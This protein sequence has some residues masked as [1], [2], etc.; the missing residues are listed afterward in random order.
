MATFMPIQ[1]TSGFVA[2]ALE[3]A[4]LKSGASVSTDFLWESLLSLL[5]SRRRWGPI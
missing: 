1:L 3:G 5:N 4:L 2:A